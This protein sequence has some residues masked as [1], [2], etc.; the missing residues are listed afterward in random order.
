MDGLTAIANRSVL[1]NSMLSGG[2]RGVIKASFLL[3]D[4]DFFKAYYD[5]YGHLAGDYCLRQVAKRLADVIRRPADLLARYGGEELSS[6]AET[7]SDGAR[8]CGPCPDKI[9]LVISRTLIPG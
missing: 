1:M 2:V 9:K 3:M 4:I 7:D 8:D 6:A 5:H